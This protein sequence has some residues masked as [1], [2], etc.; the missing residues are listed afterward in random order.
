L[1]NESSAAIATQ[2]TNVNNLGPATLSSVTLSGA[3]GFAEPQLKSAWVD[4]SDG[5]QGAI[6]M[7]S[8]LD[9]GGG[10][11]HLVAGATIPRDPANTPYM[12]LTTPYGSLG[13]N[14]VVVVK[15]PRDRCTVI[16]AVTVTFRVGSSSELYSGSG[17]SGYSLCGAGTSLTE[18]VAAENKANPQPN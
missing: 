17:E 11:R 2:I 9:R 4:D 14:L 6:G 8:S 13:R 18:Q 7:L 16:A 3:A 5:C 15:V 12:G 10:S 1:S